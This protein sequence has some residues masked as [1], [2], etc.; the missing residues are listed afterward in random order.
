LNANTL[1]VKC[2]PNNPK[3][4][5]HNNHKTKYELKTFDSKTIHELIYQLKI[6][7]PKSRINSQTIKDI[8]FFNSFLKT[9][10]VKLDNV[11]Y[12]NS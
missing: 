8:F 7:Y 1:T 11:K 6:T 10:M 9:E 4:H 12:F 2:S 5:Q 3:D